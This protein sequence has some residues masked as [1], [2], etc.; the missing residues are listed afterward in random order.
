MD[1]PPGVRAGALLRLGQNLRKIGRRIAFTQVRNAEE[2]WAIENFL[3]APKVA[4]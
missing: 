3:P 2:V 4:K 1:D